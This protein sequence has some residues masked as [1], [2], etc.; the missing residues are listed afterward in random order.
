MANHLI[1]DF[2]GTLADSSPGIYQSFQVACYKANVSCPEFNDFCAKIGPPIQSIATHFFPFLSNDA[3]ELIRREFRGNYDATGYKNTSWYEGVAETLLTLKSL[4]HI[5]LSIVTNKPTAPTVSLVCAAGLN[6]CFDYIVGIDFPV[7]QQ[8]GQP[9]KSKSNALNYLLRKHGLSTENSI[10]VG[11]TPNDKHAAA[12]CDL[13]FVAA[14]YGFHHWKPDE[15]PNLSLS[16]FSDI[17]PIL[18]ALPES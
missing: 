14:L 7:T 6:D 2:D 11:D 3:L 17:I 15:T 13:A 9:F 4:R 5:S 10:Y 8:R 18:L 12:S 1:L 16:R